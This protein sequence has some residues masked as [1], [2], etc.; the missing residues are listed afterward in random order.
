MTTIVNYGSVWAS[1]TR[2][3][4]RSSRRRC[5]GGSAMIPRFDRSSFST[6]PAVGRQL[7]SQYFHVKQDC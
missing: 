6:A 1:C 4:L 2:D 7:D 3:G 5:D